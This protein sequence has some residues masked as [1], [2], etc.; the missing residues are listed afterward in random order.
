MVYYHFTR[1]K[2]L[3]KVMLEGLRPSCETG[4][5]SIYGGFS[6]NSNFIYLYSKETFWRIAK[7]FCLG[8]DP[9]TTVK[10]MI[11]LHIEIDN[12]LLERDYDQLLTFI[13]Y[14]KESKEWQE[15]LLS[16]VKG[17]GSELKGFTEDDAR[18]AWVFL[19]QAPRLERS[20]A[21]RGFYFTKFK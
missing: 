17:W 10:N 6:G 19:H 4:N 16:K 20:K 3:S 9:D 1:S 13:R 15:W 8:I 5:H 11:L 12:S 2:D 18:R 14:T 7:N 21:A